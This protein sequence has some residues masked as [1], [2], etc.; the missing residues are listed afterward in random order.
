MAD[1]I[2][3]EAVEKVTDTK[4][5]IVED[6]E[7]RL[8]SLPDDI[9]FSVLKR[10]N[11]LEAAR[12]SVLSRRWMNLF[13]F[14]SIIRI[15]VGS[16]YQKYKDSELTRDVLAQINANMVKM[17]KSMLPHNCQ[18]PI[19]ISLLRVKFSLVEESIDIIRCVDN[20]MANR[21]ISALQ[22]Y[23]HTETVD[24]D[25]T[26]DDKMNYGRRFMRFFD[27]GPHAFG[28]LSYLHIESVAPTINDIVTVLDKCNKLLYLSLHGCDF[29]SQAVLKIE[30]RQLTTRTL[31]NCNCERVQ[32]TCL[33]SLLRLTFQFW[34]AQENH[35]FLINVMLSELY[36]DFSCEGIWVQLEAPKLAGNWLQNLQFLCL[37]C[38]HEDSAPLSKKMHVEVL[39]ELSKVFHS[40]LLPWSTKVW[41]H[42]SCGH[43]EDEPEEFT[44]LCQQLYQK[45]CD[46]L[47]WEAPD[48]LKHYSL[49]EIVINEYQIGEKFTR[50][51]R[52]VVEAA[53][54]LELVILL[55][56]ARCEHCKFYLSTRYPRTEEERFLTSKQILEWSSRP[57]KI[58]IVT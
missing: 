2:R 44:E 8:S 47:T 48:D 17:T 58:E 33:P 18:C 19:S 42:T 28:G 21:E 29:G 56:R 9:L 49:K 26:Q 39:Y 11:L 36:L 25:C 51:T 43:E 55:D 45:K 22:F 3:S 6:D 35:E 40:Y 27:A 32:L 4:V 13:R 50:Y 12:T 46:S 15:D 37:R 5:A 10:L 34:T 53:A 31:S 14:R 41:D 16:F 57:I 52:R 1:F 24:L 30:H 20:A 23:M 38:I 54:N 7:D